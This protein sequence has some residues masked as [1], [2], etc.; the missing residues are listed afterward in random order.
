MKADNWLP[1]RDDLL[2]CF[3][4][5]DEKRCLRLEGVRVRRLIWKRMAKNRLG[6]KN[7]A[8]CPTPYA[9]RCLITFH[10]RFIR[11]IDVK[12]L[13]NPVATLD[14]KIER[15]KM[16]WFEGFRTSGELLAVDEISAHKSQFCFAIHHHF[17]PRTSI[18][19]LLASLCFLLYKH[20]NY[21]VG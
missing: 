11:R 3:C 14:M 2:W 1:L 16:I 8:N 10:P 21:Y 6:D 20:S 12:R 9:F 19:C 5:S 15:W 7:R 17:L 13:K 4:E 18:L